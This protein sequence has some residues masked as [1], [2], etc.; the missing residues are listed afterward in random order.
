MIVIK[1]F[2]LGIDSSLPAAD[3]GMFDHQQRQ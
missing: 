2:R 1:L 3:T